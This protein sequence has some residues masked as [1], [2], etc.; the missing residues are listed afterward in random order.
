MADYVMGLKTIEAMIEKAD[1]KSKE[2]ESMTSAEVLSVSREIWIASQA[3]QSTMRQAT[4]LLQNTP[5]DEN[6]AVHAVEISR[7]A[8][9][10]DE[11]L[12]EIALR[13]QDKVLLELG[14]I[15]RS[16]TDSHDKKG[17]N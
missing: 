11:S 12:R 13:L 8:H 10:I 5:F 14:R 17:M 2:I 1:S 15:K 7:I 3:F 4:D 6:E 9:N 16:R